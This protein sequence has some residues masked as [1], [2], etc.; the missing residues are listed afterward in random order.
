MVIQ[1]KFIS[2]SVVKHSKE[3]GNMT[4]AATTFGLGLKN[5][6][7]PD[8]IWKEDFL[9]SLGSGQGIWNLRFLKNFP[10][11]LDILEPLEKSLEFCS[12]GQGLDG[13]WNVRLSPGKCGMITKW[14]E[15]CHYRQSLTLWKLNLFPASFLLTNG[16][17]EP[18]NT[19][20][21]M[22]EKLNLS[23]H[24]PWGGAVK[25]GHPE[26]SFSPRVLGFLL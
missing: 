9:E 3:T 8:L 14:D 15:E 25:V 26:N 13:P 17:M 5:V 23:G 12:C 1:L 10:C 4:T 18:I 21:G 7:N 2:T 11:P 20:N 24:T 22:P 16:R 19:R 6:R